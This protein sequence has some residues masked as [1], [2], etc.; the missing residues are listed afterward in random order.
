MPFPWD[1]AAGAFGI[2]A[3]IIIAGGAILLRFQRDR[4]QFRL[5]HAALDKG[6][7]T[8][9]G[10]IPPWLLSLRQGV[11]T[12]VLGIGLVGAG[13]GLHAA[14]RHISEAP[15]PA[16]RPTPLARLDPDQHDFRP[17]RPPPPEADGFAPPN[18][19]LRPPGPPAGP[20]GAGPPEARAAGDNPPRPDGPPRPDPATERW[21]RIQTQQLAGLLSACAGAILVLLGIVRIAF[22]RSER[23]YTT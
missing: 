5:L 14:A 7:T 16:T 2:A 6:I 21:H 9:P 3:A 12:L 23:K 15:Q 1:I 10:S 20:Q 8:L 4:Y 22:A 13:I 11:L 19:P 17:P 18:A